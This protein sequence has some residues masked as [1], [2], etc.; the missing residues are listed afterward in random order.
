MA[1]SITMVIHFDYNEDPDI[2]S[3]LDE[4]DEKRIIK[5]FERN[6]IITRA[7]DIEWNGQDDGLNLIHHWNA[8]RKSKR[9][10]DA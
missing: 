4:I 2:Y 10:E 8:Q 5:I 3:G 6:H 1:K 7:P 9:Q